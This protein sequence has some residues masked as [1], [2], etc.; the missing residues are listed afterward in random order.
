MEFA[1]LF[2]LTT[3]AKID[4]RR[5]RGRPCG[6][7]RREV[8]NYGVTVTMRG[9]AN[10]NNNRQ[11]PDQGIAETEHRHSSLATSAQFEQTVLGSSEIRKLGEGITAHREAKL[12]S[13]IIIPLLNF[14]NF[15]EHDNIRQMKKLARRAG[16]NTRLYILLFSMAT[17]RSY[18]QIRNVRNNSLIF[19]L[20]QSQA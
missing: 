6:A 4:N 17:F 16:T 13:A 9:H 8:I 5:R 20:V 1:R 15:S 7:V 14:I 11:L 2:A 3:T 18:Q 19:S 12:F 10:A